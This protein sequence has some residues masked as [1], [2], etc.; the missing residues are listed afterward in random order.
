MAVSAIESCLEM[1]RKQSLSSHQIHLL[2]IQLPYRPYL[3]LRSTYREKFSEYPHWERMLATNRPRY[4]RSIRMWKR[5]RETVREYT[6]SK[7]LCLCRRTEEKTPLTVETT[8]FY[9]LLMTIASSRS[10]LGHERELV[11]WRTLRSSR[12]VTACR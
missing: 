5:R 12:T 1:E 2:I 8:A 11:R 10:G 6:T 4:M 7:N 9:S 3:R